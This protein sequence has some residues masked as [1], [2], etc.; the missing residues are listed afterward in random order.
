MKKIALILISLI[1][2]AAGFAGTSF[3]FPTGTQ[4]DN[5]LH[6]NDTGGRNAD[7]VIGNNPPFDFLGYYWNGPVLEIYT[8][9][10]AGLDGMVQGAY[11]GD[12]FFLAPGSDP[13][14]PDGIIA[15]WALRDHT[16]A[17]TGE[18]DD[19]I[20]AGDLYTVEGL[21]YSDDYFPTTNVSKFGDNEFVTGF[22]SVG[23]NIQ[24]A[25]FQVPDIPD[26]PSVDGLYIIS[27]DLTSLL[28]VGAD[29]D[30]FA[31]WMVRTQHTCANDVLASVPEPATLLLLGTGLIGLAGFGRR[32]FKNR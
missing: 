16:S 14:S 1:F 18:S 12:V 30:F 24:P 11:L 31:S 10:N 4:L 8:N 25:Y 28:P 13:S 9:W 20:M 17:I 19:G 32:K 7:D 15:G 6:P 23:A 22:G 2:L 26:H 5:Y 27:A 21:R 3:A 29:S